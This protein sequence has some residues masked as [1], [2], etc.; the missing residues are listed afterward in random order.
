MRQVESQCWSYPKSRRP[1]AT[2]RIT[3]F[4]KHGTAGEHDACVGTMRLGPELYEGVGRTR[5]S[6][7]DLVSAEEFVN[8]G[9]G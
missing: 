7:V 6:E 9:A 1:E 8:Q 4:D 3:Q 5:R 2:S